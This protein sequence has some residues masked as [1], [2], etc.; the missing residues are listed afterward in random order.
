MKKIFRSIS[1]YLVALGLLTGS[2][3]SSSPPRDPGDPPPTE[4]TW[5]QGNWDQLNWQ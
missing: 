4:L 2:G 1:V 3:G 5:D